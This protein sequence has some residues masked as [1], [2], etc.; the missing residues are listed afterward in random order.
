M[1]TRRLGLLVVA[2]ASVGAAAGAAPTPVVG[3]A[4]TATPAAALPRYAHVFV[5]IAENKGYEL[6]IGPDSAAPKLNALAQRYGLATQFF[7]ETHPSEGNYVAMVGGSTF[8]IHDDDAF[9]CKPGQKDHWCPQA[10]AADY[11]D[12]TVT[13]RSLVDQL[14]EHGLTWK[15]YF[16]SLP[17]PGSLAVRWPT[18]EAPVPGTPAQ[19]Y[20]AKHNAFINFRRVQDDPQRASRLVGFDELYRDIAS[21]NMPSYAHIVPNQCNDMH[22]RPAGKDVPEDCASSNVRAL[23]ARGD[24]VIG[25]L[26]QRIMDSPLWAAKENAAIVITFDENDKDERSGLDQGC[27]GNEPGSASNAGGGRIPTLVITN[28]GPRGLKDDTPYNHYSLLRTTEALFGINEFLA[29]AAD[30][31]RGVRVM[32][33][34]FAVTH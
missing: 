6:I 5:I 25:D 32:A 24:R 8:G 19:M 22:G 30:T 18:A 4:V 31:D 7:A 26:A 15:G 14:E 16:E 20:A 29:H 10:Q 1:R 21:G 2:L 34:V 3:A 33:P 13:A 11:V 28:H 23:I 17:E 27:C 12:H 9:Y